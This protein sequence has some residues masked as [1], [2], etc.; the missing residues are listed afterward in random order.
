LFDTRLTYCEAITRKPVASTPSAVIAP[1]RALAGAKE[2]SA[3]ER[4]VVSTAAVSVAEALSEEGLGST[5]SSRTGGREGAFLDVRTP[6]V[7]I[8]SHERLFRYVP[9]GVSQ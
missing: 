8:F 5:N 7:K 2:A 3:G 1:A 9:D 6:G 4:A